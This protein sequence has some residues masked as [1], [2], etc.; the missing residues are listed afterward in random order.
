[1]RFWN[2][3]SLI[4]IIILLIYD[5]DS[6]YVYERA[7]LFMKSFVLFHSFKVILFGFRFPVFTVDGIVSALNSILSFST[8][9]RMYIY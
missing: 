1:M 5:N 9:L 7:A 2:S 8:T 4:I 6:T 3:V